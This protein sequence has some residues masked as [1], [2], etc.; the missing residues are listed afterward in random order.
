MKPIWECFKLFGLNHGN[1]PG[2]AKGS[3]TYLPITRLDVEDIKEQASFG[4][5]AGAIIEENTHRLAHILTRTDTG[6][7]YDTIQYSLQ[8]ILRNTVEHS[9]SDEVWYCA[10]YLPTTKVVELAIIDRGL[11][12]VVVSAITHT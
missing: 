3:N 10:Q 9:R 1:K 2:E 5:A 12:S 6:P 4:T 8:E 11:G 7:S